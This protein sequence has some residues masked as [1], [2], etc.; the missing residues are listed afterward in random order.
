MGHEAIRMRRPEANAAVPGKGGC[1][2]SRVVASVDMAR[3]TFGVAVVMLMSASAHAERW[4]VEDSVNARLESND[5]VSLAPVSPG[6]VHSLYL[7]GALDASQQL[8]NAASRL[9]ADA[10]LIRQQ[11]AG[12]QDRVDGQLL[13]LQSLSDPLNTLTASVQY[14]Q[15]F[16]NLIS[17]ADVTQGRG[18]RRTSVASV[19]W[20]RSLSERLSANM[21]LSADR[22]TY[23]AQLPGAVDYRDASVSAGV[24]YA[25]SEV[26]SMGLQTSRTAFRTA[27]DRNRS[28][29]D[30]VNLSLSR[31]TG[32]RTGG[33]V[34][35][36]VY[37]T[38][39]LA[40]IDEVACPLALALCNA[41]FVPYVRFQQRVD[42]SRRGLQ[43]SGSYRLQIDEVTDGIFGIARQ[44][45]P[46]G[47]GTLVRNDTLSLGLN[48]ALSP[49]LSATMRFARSHSTLQDGASAVQPGQSTIAASLTRQF[50]MDLTGQITA[51]HN[52]SDPY[53]KGGGARANSISI[54]LQYDGPKIDASR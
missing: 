23:G 37:R 19:A 1:K 7:S 24:S 12:A 22:T 33:S 21:Q 46:S 15:D 32:E 43:F 39:S 45:S 53:A 26:T 9:K 34:S 16:N 25:L 29:T 52:R 5:N 11:G 18:R 54:S 48:R 3:C 38:Q 41:G 50:A 28:D 17:T 40:R 31:P 47:T 49:T 6:T 35:V 14:L 36:G 2:M 20:S 44:Q 4:L 8:E 51:Q 42:S 13:L 30:A 10:T 27:D